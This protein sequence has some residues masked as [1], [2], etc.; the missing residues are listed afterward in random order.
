MVAAWP[1]LLLL[2][3][4]PVRV[5][6]VGA[7][8][9][10]VSETHGSWTFHLELA[11][12]FS[13]LLAGLCWAYAAIVALFLLNFSIQF[14]Q[15]RT[16]I[17]SSRPASESLSSLFDSVRASIRA[18]R[19]ELRM[20]DGLPSPAAT[21]WWRPRILVPDEFLSR[22]E[23]PQLVSILRHEL[24][25]VRRRDYLW[26]RLA[27]VGCY[28]IFFHPAAWLLRRHLRWDR[29][30]ACDDGSVDR[31]DACRLEYAACLTSLAKWRVYG[32]G[33]SGPIDFLSAPTLLGARVR[34]M[35][36]PYHA[37]YSAAKKGAIACLIAL[38]LTIALRLLPEVTVAPISPASATPSDTATMTAETATPLQHVSTAD[39]NQGLQRLRLPVPEAK[40]QRVHTH[41]ASS[42]PQSPRNIRGVSGQ[43]SHASEPK[44]V[45]GP[46]W[47]LIPNA[48]GWALRSV[49]SGFSKVG[50]HLAFARHP[51]EPTAQ[52]GQ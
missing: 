44:P 11:P 47:R 35:V 19:C 4:L 48:G 15:F 52:V 25:H 8:L 16:L 22:V 46:L 28:L 26:D 41:L 9:A 7:P 18:P 3:A 36:S 24:I 33:F 50:S 42:T 14:R 17:R 5:S 34:A 6:S 40:V 2:S 10:G 29:E 45:R 13:P 23:T 39:R 12:R 32:G 43:S 49:K 37:N 27:T 20:I 21:G 51:K 38:S 1:G 31:S 30:L